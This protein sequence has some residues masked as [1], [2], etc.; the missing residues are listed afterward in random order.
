MEENNN[1]IINTVS[2]GA[3]MIP[4]IVI[5]SLLLFIPVVNNIIT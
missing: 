4:G 3:V 2:F 5:T 1:K